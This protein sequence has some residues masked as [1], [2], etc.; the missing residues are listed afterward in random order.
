[1]YKYIDVA[2]TR[3]GY[4]TIHF[5]FGVQVFFIFFFFFFFIVMV[6]IWF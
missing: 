2:S 4:K 3:L 5:I 6:Y 1:M